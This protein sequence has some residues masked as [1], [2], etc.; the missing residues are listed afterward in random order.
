MPLS[1]ALLRVNPDWI[2][3]KAQEGY[4]WYSLNQKESPVLVLRS[5]IDQPDVKHWSSDRS[6]ASSRCLYRPLLPFNLSARRLPLSPSLIY[7]CIVHLQPAVWDGCLECLC[8]IL[9]L[10][11]FHPETFPF[12]LPRYAHWH[13]THK[14]ML[15]Y[16]TCATIMHTQTHTPT[17]THTHPADLSQLFKPPTQAECVCV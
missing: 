14:P 1:T 7:M 16:K 15:T 5:V 3:I 4:F 2:Q 11:H 13:D 10:I 9:L 17:H 6:V 8:C 12:P